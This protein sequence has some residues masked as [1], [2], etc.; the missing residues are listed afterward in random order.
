MNSIAIPSWTTEGLLP[1]VNSPD[2]T[3]ADRSPYRVSLTDLVL[4]FSTSSKRQEILDGFLHYREELH[5]LGFIQ[6][7]QWLDGSFL[8]EVETLEG[9]PPNDVDVVTFYDLPQDQTQADL[10]KANA[11]LFNHEKVKK[12]FL[13]DGY[14]VQRT[15]NDID[16]LIEYTTYWY[17]MWSHRRNQVWRGYLQVD[18]SP[19]EDETAKANLEKIMRGEV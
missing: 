17:S 13:V 2:G 16:G 14:L 12:Q 1:P 11:D 15:G 6:G 19:G 3:S 9:R 18:L 4:R 10:L 5:V 7:F 8:E